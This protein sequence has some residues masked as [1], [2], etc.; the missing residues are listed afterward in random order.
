M[1]ILTVHFHFLVKLLQINGEPESVRRALYAISSIMYKFGPK[2]EIPLVTSASEAAPSI[3]IPSDIPI[4]QS[5]AYG[6]IDPI[7]PSGSVPPIL[8]AAHVSDL[9]NYGDLGNSWSVYASTLPV[10]PVGSGSLSE[11]LIIRVL[12]PPDKIGRVIGKAGSTIKSIRQ[13]SGAHIEV[14]DSKK[15]RDDCI[16]TVRATEVCF[17]SVLMTSFYLISHEG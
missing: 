11:E 13:A 4:F 3:I 17:S 2:E 12:C 14:D 15:D 9:H 10:V 6:T 8:G 7:V 1:L 16:I 5:G